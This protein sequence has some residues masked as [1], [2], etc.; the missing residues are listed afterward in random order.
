M[1]AVLWHLFQRQ[2]LKGESDV[3][4]G[5]QWFDLMLCIRRSQRGRVHILGM[6]NRHRQTA[7]TQL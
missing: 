1:G 6:E 3:D 7:A 2:Q 4:E 5:R